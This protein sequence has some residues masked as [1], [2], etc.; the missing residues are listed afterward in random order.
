MTARRGR[1]SGTSARE[2][3]LI[4]LRLFT[5]Q[6]YDETTVEEIATAAGVS[7]RTFFRYFDSKSDVLW[8]EFDG[9][10]DALRSAFA[11]ID[12]DVPL[13]EAIRQVVIGVNQYHAEDV[14]ELRTRMNLITS[15]PALQASAAPHYDAWERAVTDFA[16][17]RLGQPADSLYPLAVG[18]TTLAACRAAYD[19]WVARAD[20]DLTVY[21]D[22]ALRALTKGF[23]IDTS[24]V[25]PDLLA[26][27]SKR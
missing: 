2:L 4:A 9:E 23:D 24:D 22:L 20:N 14:P 18:R 6:G 21:M 17:A 3:E 16:A 10:V 13:M 8:A 15:V 11:Q 25:D 7:R 26:D 27:P 19:R 1:P 12:D 5:E